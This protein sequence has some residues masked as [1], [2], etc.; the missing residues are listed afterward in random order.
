M[1]TGMTCGKVFIL[2]CLKQKKKKK[3]SYKSLFVILHV[4]GNN[5]LWDYLIYLK[6]KIHAKMF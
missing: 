5:K 6:V 4:L 1:I 2:D 3:I